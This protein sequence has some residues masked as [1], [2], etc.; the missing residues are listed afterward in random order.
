MV[1]YS[2][3]MLVFL[4]GDPIEFIGKQRF[5]TPEACNA[6]LLK[7][8]MARGPAPWNTDLSCR[9]WGRVA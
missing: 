7:M 5:S 1:L 2:V 6:E 8:A 9:L 3:F 4:G